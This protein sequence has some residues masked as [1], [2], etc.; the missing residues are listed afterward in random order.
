MGSRSL[1]SKGVSR[2]LFWTLYLAPLLWNI[3]SFFGKVVIFLWCQWPISKVFFAIVM[4]SRSLFSNW[5]PWSTLGHST[6]LTFCI[7]K[8]PIFAKWFFSWAHKCLLLKF[9]NLSLWGR[10]IT[11]VDQAEKTPNLTHSV[12]NQNSYFCKVFPLASLTTFFNEV[13]KLYV[14][15]SRSLFTEVDI[16]TV[17]TVL[18]FLRIPLIYDTVS[19]RLIPH[20]QRA[21]IHKGEKGRA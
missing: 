16:L 7:L 10:E 2:S 17:L 9:K 15:R 20:P 21:E 14:M 13:E 6:S 1:L 12:R 5:L 11:V 3:K 18:T 19:R 8:N 4:G